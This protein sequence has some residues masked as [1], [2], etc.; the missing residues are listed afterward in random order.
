MI[1]CLE[2][3]FPDAKINIDASSIVNGSLK[4]VVGLVWNIFYVFK[5]KKV[6]DGNNPPGIAS[7]ISWLTKRVEKFEHVRVTDLSSSFLD[8]GFLLCALLCSFAPT[9]LEYEFLQPQNAKKN[10]DRCFTKSKEIFDVPLL[11]DSTDLVEK[12]EEVSMVLYLTMYF[13][14]TML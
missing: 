11:L 10:L 14:K 9:A 3:N 5:V 6:V 12:V 8:G 7:L 4:C 2:E 13:E 1:H